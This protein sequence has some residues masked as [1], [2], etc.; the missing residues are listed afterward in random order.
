MKIVRTRTDHRVVGINKA[1]E[2]LGISRWTL[3]R[4]IASGKIPFIRFPAGDGPH[5][6]MRGAKIDLDDLDAFI[7]RN[8]DRND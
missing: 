6:D 1:A 8:K 7:E 4:W 3:R 5:N 2:Y